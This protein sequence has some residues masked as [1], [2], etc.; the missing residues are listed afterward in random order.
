MDMRGANHLT[1]YGNGGKDERRRKRKTQRGEWWEEGAR[2][3]EVGSPFDEEEVEGG[4][5]VQMLRVRSWGS[6]F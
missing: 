6:G 3:L 5:W 1:N 4:L 2:N